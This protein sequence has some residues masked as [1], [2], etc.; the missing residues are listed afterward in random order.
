MK[1]AIVGSRYSEK[2]SSNP[3]HTKLEFYNSVY[4]G[5]TELILEP[6]ELIIS[7]GAVGIDRAAE[8]FAEEFKIP[9]LIIKP[10]WDRFGRAAG[11][12]RNKDIVAAA[13][14]VIAFWNGV[15]KGTANSIEHAKRLNKGLDIVLI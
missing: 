11:M 1:L 3:Y 12:I 7:G 15:S 9:T 14:H 4:Y 10:D 6:I 13:D 8:E 5:V 2:S